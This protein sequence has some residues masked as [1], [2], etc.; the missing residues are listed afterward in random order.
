M[1]LWP[2]LETGLV[3]AVGRRIQVSG[4]LAA[5]RPP[6]RRKRWVVRVLVGTAALTAVAVAVVFVGHGGDATQTAMANPLAVAARS[7]LHQPSLFPRNDQYFYMRVQGDTIAGMSTKAGTTINALETVSTDS[8][9]SAD[10]PDITRQTVTS[11]HFGSPAAAAQWKAS[12][13]NTQVGVEHTESFSRVPTRGYWFHSLGL[14]T[15]RQMLALPSSPGALFARLFNR[16]QVR[17]YLH[18]EASAARSLY[19][20]HV[21]AGNLS[22]GPFPP[23]V[24]SALYGALALVPGVKSIGYD[25]DL[26]GRTGTAVALTI[27]GVRFE[28]IFDPTTSALLGIRATALRA[29]EGIPKGHVYLNLAFLNEAVTNTLTIPNTTR[30]Q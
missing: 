8:W 22:A 20:F 5:R 13:G 25:T 3:N 23:K 21:L 26:I 1:S 19:E 27:G 12:G 11:I 10:L 6:A 29:E 4:P 28:V 18:T 15:R 24:R 30:L 14:L 16:P 7:A 9:Q 2:E 17:K